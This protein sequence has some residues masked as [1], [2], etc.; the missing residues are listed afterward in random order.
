[1]VSP[2]L[3]T[4][5]PRATLEQAT[6]W[7]LAVFKHFPHGPT[8]VVFKTPLCGLRHSV[9]SDS[10]LPHGL[11]PTRFFCPCDF[12]GKN[13]GVS[14]HFLLQGVFLTQ[15]LNLG[16]LPWQVDSLPLRH[17]GSPCAHT[18]PN[19]KMLTVFPFESRLR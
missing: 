11:K 12:P 14:C 10:L 6:G 3:C 17:L 5:L 18:D 2:A 9:V 16:L 4:C 19:D 8:H 15:G 13:T 1:M 7:H